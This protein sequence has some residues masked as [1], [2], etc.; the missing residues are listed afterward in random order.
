MLK[1]EGPRFEEQIHPRVF[2]SIRRSSAA[3][4]RSTAT[5]SAQAVDAPA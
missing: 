2:R 4:E 1:N 5:A 3:S